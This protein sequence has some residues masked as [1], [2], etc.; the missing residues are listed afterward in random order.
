MV[1]DSEIND[2]L[3]GTYNR[4]D[5]QRMLLRYMR[6]AA[7]HRLW[8]DANRWSARF[9][10]GTDPKDPFPVRV[11]VNTLRP[12][13][14]RQ[15]AGLYL[16][17]PAP[18]VKA[19]TIM[20]S[21]SRGRLRQ[22]DAEAVQHA[23]KEWLGRVNVQTQNE[24]ALEMASLF[25]GAAL[26]IGYDKSRKGSGVDRVWLNVIPPWEALWDERATEL[27][28]QRYRGHLRWETKA[29]AERSLGVELKDIPT[30]SIADYL[31]DGIGTNR[32]DIGR[33]SRGKGYVQVLDW[34]DYEEE[35]F[36]V[37]LVDGGGGVP[38]LR[39]VEGVETKPMPYDWP[40]GTPL[41]PIEPVILANTVGFPMAPFALGKAVYEETCEKSLLMTI[42]VNAYRRD[43]A[44]VILYLKEQGLEQDVVTKIANAFDTEF[45][46]VA[47]EQVT[48]LSKLL[49]P[50]TMPKIADTL[51]QAREWLSLSAAEQSAI[52]DIGRGRSEST[53]YASAT[54]VQELSSGDAAA[55]SAPAERMRLVLARVTAAMLR[56]V[57]LEGAGL[58]IV[59]GNETVTLTPEKLRAAWVV[60]IEDAA[61]AA[62]A[63][64]GRAANLMSAIP[65]WAQ[66]VATASSP[67]PAIADEVKVANERMAD[68]VADTFEWPDNM[69][70]HA[71]RGQKPMVKPPEP[72]ATPDAEGFLPPGGPPA[73]DAAPT[74]EA[75]PA[76]AGAGPV[77]PHKVVGDI[78][79]S[80][81]SPEQLA[82]VTAAVGGPG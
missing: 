8:E 10:T 62:N 59:R 72:P 25:P 82:R 71:L 35:T 16:R 48:D 20:S 30:Y 43:A 47:P 69:R 74:A 61:A 73:P 19:P 22:E 3:L 75:G 54:T 56:I 24:Q 42:L 13:L 81:L 67:D 65:V 36:T 53:K 80:S 33:A 60:K 27:Q 49:Y 4:W 14:T 39:R 57:G 70:M 23:A 1:E 46:G 50:L 66:A 31:V 37:F 26:K 55:T 64:A 45:V 77:D 6:S 2:I 68:L 11:Q 32:G 34:Y 21:T 51:E 44:R 18:E 17:A 63:R 28:Q 9:G 79:R 52:S 38:T 58:K 78:L 7:D 12:W 5:Q 29:E 40:D 15:V 41:V 76:A